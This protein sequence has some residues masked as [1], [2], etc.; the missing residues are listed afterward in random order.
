MTLSQTRF[1]ESKRNSKKKVVVFMIGGIT[2]QEN[3]ELQIL[4]ERDGF[5]AICGSNLIINSEK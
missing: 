4:G 5:Q 1:E 2:Y 3:R